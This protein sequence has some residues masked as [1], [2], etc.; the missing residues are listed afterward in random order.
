MMTVDLTLGLLP[1]E[2]QLVS[3][4]PSGGHAAAT[5]HSHKSLAARAGS[6]KHVNAAGGGGG[7][8]GTAARRNQVNIKGL[9]VDLPLD[10]EDY[11]VPSPQSPQQ[12]VRVIRHTYY[13][14]DQHAFQWDRLYRV[15]NV[16][17][18]NLPLT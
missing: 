4:M 9:R 5:M 16:V 1:D 17:D 2:N 6:S 10:D 14:H 11:L 18:E 12:Q 7:T 15:T 13:T 3:S 8:A